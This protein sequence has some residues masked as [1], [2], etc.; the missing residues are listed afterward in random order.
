MSTPERK[1][2]TFNVE[3]ALLPST[4]AEMITKL[5]IIDVLADDERG[6]LDVV[7]ANKTAVRFDLQLRR[8][9]PGTWT[10][11]ETM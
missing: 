10:Y 8:C 2:P 3:R 5:Q 4:A 11:K 1:P 9:W 7:F 6:R